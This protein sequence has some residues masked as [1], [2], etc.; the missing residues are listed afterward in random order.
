MPVAYTKRTVICKIAAR[1]ISNE[2][3]LA[4]GHHVVTFEAD[5]VAREARPGQFIAVAAD[6]G[7]Q[8]LRRPFSV[9]ETNPDAGTASILFSTYGPTTRVMASAQ[10]GDFLDI[11]GPLGGR[12]FVPDLRP[13]THHIMVGGGYGVPPLAFL[14][15]HILAQNT[16][17]SVSFINGARTADF[18]VGTDGLEAIGAKLLPATDDGSHGYHGLVT[19]VLGEILAARQEHEPVHVYCC[20]PTPMMKAV[21]LMALEKNVPCHVSLEV[22]MPCGIGICMGCAVEKC[23]GSFVRGCTDGPVFSAGEVVW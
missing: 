11:I 3:L 21:A 9:F 19:G 10:P 22:F 16:N 4:P 8:F 18:L 1:I 20:G 12:P 7:T 5:A 14:T 13:N 15:R 2:K 17:A 23:D 6:T